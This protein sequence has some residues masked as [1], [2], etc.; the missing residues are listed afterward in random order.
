MI[1]AEGATGNRD[2][3]LSHVGGQ[4]DEPVTG[5]STLKRFLLS[6]LGE[7]G[8]QWH[9]MH[10]AGPGCTA[11]TIRISG[12]ISPFRTRGPTR[13]VLGPAAPAFEGCNAYALQSPHRHK[14][15]PVPWGAEEFPQLPVYVPKDLL[16][17][18]VLFAT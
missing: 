14:L 8:V 3:C 17:E 13:V 1:A 4:N 11:C 12:T 16:P 5:R 15:D 7:H 18:H 6:R 9:Y 10:G 2:R